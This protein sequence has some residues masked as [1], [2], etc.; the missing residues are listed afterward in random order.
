MPHR[1]RLA[2]LIVLNDY[3]LKNLLYKVAGNNDIPEEII[4]RV[5]D[6]PTH[7]SVSNTKKFNQSTDS[8]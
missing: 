8:V 5:D 3:P 2:T 7:I 6:I 4:D 1:G